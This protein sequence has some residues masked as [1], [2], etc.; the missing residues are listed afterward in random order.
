MKKQRLQIEIET[1]F[2]LIGVS[3]HLKD[4]RFVWGVNKFLSTNFVKIKNN[5]TQDIKTS[6]YAHQMDLSKAYIFAN[7]TNQEVLVTTK[8]E[9]D[10]W[11]QINNVEIQSETDRWRRKLKQIPQILT[12]YEEKNKKIKEQFVF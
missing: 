9:I 8:P 10:Y 7:R 1:N 3:C 4:Y 2:C 5:K 6:K 12:T 11:V